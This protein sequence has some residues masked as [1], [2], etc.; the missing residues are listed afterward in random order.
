MRQKYF[1]NPGYDMCTQS[2]TAVTAYLSDKHLPL[3][4]CIGR[5][6]TDLAKWDK[7]FQWG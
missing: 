6:S 1:E 4:D 5:Y 2:R 3:F 7:L